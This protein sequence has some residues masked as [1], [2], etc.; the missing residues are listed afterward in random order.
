MTCDLC[1]NQISDELQSYMICTRFDRVNSNKR[2]CFECFNK[3]K[4]AIDAEE[5][6]T[7]L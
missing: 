5:R 3:E 2:V 1:P 6:R 7:D 4:A